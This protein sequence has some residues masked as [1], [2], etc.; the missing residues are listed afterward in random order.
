MRSKIADKQIELRHVEML[1]FNLLI[2]DEEEAIWGEF[3][4]RNAGSK[5]FLSNDQM[6]IGLVK[7][8]FNNLWMQSQKV[9]ESLN[10]FVGENK[11]IAASESERGAHI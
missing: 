5:I 8:A 11:T 9:D 7:M 2:V 3:Q 1:P 4:P 10:L 6:Q